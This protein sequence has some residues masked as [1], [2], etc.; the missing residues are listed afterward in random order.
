MLCPR[1]SGDALQIGYRFG[2]KLRFSAWQIRYRFIHGKRFLARVVSADCGSPYSNTILLVL[3]HAAW[4][5]VRPTLRGKFQ[6]HRFSL[7]KRFF[8]RAKL[9]EFRASL[10]YYDFWTKILKILVI[11]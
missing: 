3:E 6:K 1:S 8:P 2:K 7:P 9:L 11:F 10:W 4:Q 5:M